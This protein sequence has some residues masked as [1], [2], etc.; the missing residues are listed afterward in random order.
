[1]RSDDGLCRYGGIILLN[2]T[3]SIAGPTAFAEKLAEV[4]VIDDSSIDGTVALL[5]AVRLSNESVPFN[6]HK[7]PR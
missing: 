1:M 6:I 5:S 4:F 7:T 2:R 3:V